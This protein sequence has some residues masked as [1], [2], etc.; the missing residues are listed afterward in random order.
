[1]DSLKIE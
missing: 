1:S